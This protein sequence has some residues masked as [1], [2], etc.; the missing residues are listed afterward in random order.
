MAKQNSDS[1]AT[2]IASDSMQSDWIASLTDQEAAELI[3]NWEF[4]ARPEQLPANTPWKVWL[5]LAGRGWGKSRTGAEWVRAYAENN[6]NAR[7]AAVARTAADVRDVMIEGESG[8]MSVC[9]PWNYPTYE[10]SKRRVTWPNGAMVT[11]YSADKPDALRGPQHTAAWCFTAGTKILT[12]SGEIPIED[13]QSGDYVWTRCGLSPVVAVGSRT[14]MV[15]KIRFSNGSV[16]EVTQ[17]HPIFS[18]GKWVPAG[19]L[20]KGQCVTHVLNGA[21]S[22][23]TATQAGTTN[24][25][26]RE[27]NKGEIAIDCIERFIERI[28]GISQKVGIFTI[29][30]AIGLTTPLITWLYFTGSIKDFFSKKTLSPDAIGLQKICSNA[31]AVFVAKTSDVK[32]QSTLSVKH[33]STNER[34]KNDPKKES[35]VKTSPQFLQP[36]ADDF[37][38]NVASTWERVGLAKV[39]NIQV[40]DTPE[41]F[42][43]G[44]LVHNCD[45]I[46]AWRYT[47]AWDQLQLGLRLGDDPKCIVTTTPRPTAFIK[48][49]YKDTNTYVTTG[50]TEDNAAN[51]AP[52]FLHTVKERYEGTRLGAQELQGLILED[53]A[54]AL[55]N[56]DSIARIEDCDLPT[57]DRIVVAIDPA[58]TNSETS[59]ET[60]IVVCG[61]SNKRGY[62]LGDYSIKASPDTWARRALAA[63]DEHKADLIIGEVNNG[64]DLVESIMRTVRPTINFKAVRASRGKVARAEPVSALYEQGKVLHAGV[65][66]ELEDQMTSYVPG[67]SRKSPDRMDALVWGMSEL[68]CNDTGVTAVSVFGGQKDPWKW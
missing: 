8:I 33:A 28:M 50:T 45:E 47:D 26:A 35:F 59:D 7:I 13:I 11:T 64:G 12:R 42:A 55:W 27:V 41:Y 36:V 65:F 23:G 60:G 32:S 51:L 57:M 56:L 52:S 29:K 20:S 6:S 53:I 15:G 21:E 37:A 67:V 3:Y 66:K 54:G 4:L 43:N 2:I 5:V 9:P 48:R 49:L 25:E 24:I 58:V 22:D 63:Y 1:L 46:A 31:L 39:F 17:D 38:V 68:L 44:I 16:L 61:I 19:V 62:V 34:I 40:E 30:T 14:E 18:N 10:P